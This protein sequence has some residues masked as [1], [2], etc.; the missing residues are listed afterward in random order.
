MSKHESLS[1]KR[2]RGGRAAYKK[3]MKKLGFNFNDRF[4]PDRA[5]NAVIAERL[6]KK[7]EGK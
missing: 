3:S 7:G 1:E 4:F 5:K 6:A 2:A